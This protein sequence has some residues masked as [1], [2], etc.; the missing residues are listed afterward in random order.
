MNTHELAKKLL[1]KPDIPVMGFEVG[2]GSNERNDEE[3][4]EVFFGS[5]DSKPCAILNFG[6]LGLTEEKFNPKKK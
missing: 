1:E 3:L 4:T 6:F 2:Q 5:I